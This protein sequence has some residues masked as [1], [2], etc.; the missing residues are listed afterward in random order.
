MSEKEIQKQKIIEDIKLSNISLFK[1]IYCMK[2]RLQEF[3][4]VLCSWIL[5]IYITKAKELSSQHVKF[6]QVKFIV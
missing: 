3:L 2:I 5:S 6:N 1:Y 4:F